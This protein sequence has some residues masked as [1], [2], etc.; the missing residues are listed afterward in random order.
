MEIVRVFVLAL[1]ALDYEL[2]KKWRLKNL[3]QR[4][5]GT[6]EVGREY[7][8]GVEPY[9]PIIWTSVITGRKPEEHGIRAWWLYGGILERIRWWPII[10]HIKG[11]RRI[12]WRLGLKAHVPNRGDLRCETIFDVVKPS[13]AVYVLGYNESTEFHERLFK[14]SGWNVDGYIRKAW[15]VHEERKRAT[16][17]ALEEN[18]N[19]KLFMAY[20]DLADHVGHTYIKRNRLRVLRAY[21]EL[22]SLAGRLQELVPPGTIFLIISDHGMRAVEDDVAGRH[23]T[24]AFWSL[25]LDTDWEPRDFTDFYPKILEWTR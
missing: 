20:F 22:N 2:V 10:R 14:V 4:R 11:K 1:D 12:L 24:Y 5:Y 9:S 17:R 16:L 6:F 19:W 3:L 21:L 15:R 8:Y 7:F 25:N 23:T 18:R 13:V